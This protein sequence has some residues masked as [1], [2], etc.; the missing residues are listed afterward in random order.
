MFH[1]I[2]ITDDSSTAR[3]ITKRCLEI[4]GFSDASFLEAEDGN[5]ALQLARENPVDLMVVDLNMPNMDGRS[6]L[7]RIKC[8]HQLNHIPILIISSLVSESLEKELIELGAFAAISKPIS[9]AILANV[10]QSLS[11]EEIWGA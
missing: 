3:M 1:T 9:P 2:I 8:N 5:T 11:Q 6:L 10:L 7:K 4:A